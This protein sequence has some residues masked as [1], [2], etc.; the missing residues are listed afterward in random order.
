MPD[1]D[2]ANLILRL[3]ELRREEK[4]RM[5]RAWFNEK[6]QFKTIDE[7]EKACPMGSEE[8]AFARMV[9]SYWE[10]TASFLN[11]NVLDAQLFY[12]S[13]GELLFVYL[14]LSGMIPELRERY[15]DPTLYGELEQAAERMIEWKKDNAPEAFAFWS[16][17]IRGE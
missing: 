4:M 1:H 2:D 3:Y 10:M 5:A 7:F 13:G 17:M 6:F 15:K 8:S 11:S 12:K 14:K 9:G 16:K